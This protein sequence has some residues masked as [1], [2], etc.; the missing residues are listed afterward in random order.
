VIRASHK[1]T[2][3]V[4]TI[5][6]TRWSK[7]RKRTRDAIEAL[8]SM[9]EIAANTNFHRDHS[10]RQTSRRLEHLAS[11]G[12]DLCNKTVLEP[13]AGIG[14]HTMF[15]LD[16]GCQVTAL[17]P[18]PNN[19]AILK[20]HIAQFHPAVG[21]RLR[22][23]EG[24]ANA[25]ETLHQEFDVVHCYGLL[26]PTSDPGKVIRLPAARGSS[27]ILLETCVSPRQEGVN[28]VHDNKSVPTQA[29]DGHGCRPS[30]QWDL[31]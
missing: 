5:P 26:Y 24:D 10:V 11:L 1:P 19:C 31:R 9:A 25:M 23:I 20:E 15:Y 4:F 27:L 16:R 29:I 21:G 14:D 12:L 13:G 6:C 17:E 8:S 3:T 18:R 30:R 22:V 2:L 28:P 7:Q